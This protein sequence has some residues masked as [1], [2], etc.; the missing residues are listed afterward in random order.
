MWTLISFLILLLFCWLGLASILAFSELHKLHL[1]NSLAFVSATCGYFSFQILENISIGPFGVA[2]PTSPGLVA[3]YVDFLAGRAEPKLEVLG[4]WI[5]IALTLPG[6]T[7]VKKGFIWLLLSMLSCMP[8]RLIIVD[9]CPKIPLVTE[10]FLSVYSL[11][12]CW[13]FQKGHCMWDSK[14][15]ISCAWPERLPLMPPCPVHEMGALSLINSS[16]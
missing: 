2:H 7:L 5:Q 13:C 15:L 14:W 16:G 11:V 10:P 9:A 3:C 6:Q 8:I 4:R 1:E 12:F